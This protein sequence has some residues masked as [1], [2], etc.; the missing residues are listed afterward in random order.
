MGVELDAQFWVNIVAAVM[1]GV[2][3]WLGRTLWEAVEKLKN[4]IHEIEVGLPSNYLRKD[5]FQESMREIKDML[6]RISDKLDGK[7]D[8]R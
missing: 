8:K 4:D 6:I 2:G 7:V 1:M 5:E 3:G